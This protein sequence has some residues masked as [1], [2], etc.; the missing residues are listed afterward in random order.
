[1]IYIHINILTVRLRSAPNGKFV[2]KKK[3]MICNE[4]LSRLYFFQIHSNYI[5]IHIVF[6]CFILR[7]LSYLS[8]LYA[9]L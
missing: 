5:P 3:T 2:I 8:K 7:I 4:K 6:F 9:F 1:M